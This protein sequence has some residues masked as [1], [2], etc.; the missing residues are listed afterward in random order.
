[1]PLSLRGQIP[2]AGLT[3]NYQ[4]WYR[5]AAFTVCAQDTYYFSNGLSVTWVP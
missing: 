2:A 5:D 3:M 1:M 4:V